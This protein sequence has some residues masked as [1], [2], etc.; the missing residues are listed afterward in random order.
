[1]LRGLLPG[2]ETMKSTKRDTEDIL[3]QPP[4]LHPGQRGRDAFRNTGL[5]G[6]RNRLHPDMRTRQ[7]QDRRPLFPRILAEA[8]GVPARLVAVGKPRL[9]AHAVHDALQGR[10]RDTPRVGAAHRAQ[11]I[12]GLYCLLLAA[13]GSASVPC[14]GNRRENPLQDAGDSRGRPASGAQGAA[15]GRRDSHVPAGRG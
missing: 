1:M 3:R 6:R 8:G 2:A 14:G 12:K 9:H 5:S 10:L 13:D 4:P 7:Q 11:H 15:H